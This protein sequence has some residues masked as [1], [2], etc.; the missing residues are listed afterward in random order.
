M[1][2]IRPLPGVIMHRRNPAARVGHTKVSRLA[3]MSVENI[4]GTG[5]NGREFPKLYEE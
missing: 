2:V 5:A 4:V 1:A 3:A